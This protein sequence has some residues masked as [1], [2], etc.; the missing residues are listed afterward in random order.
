M[1][2]DKSGI[3][4]RGEKRKEERGSATRSRRVRSAPW[5]AH[6]CRPSGPKPTCSPSTC[7]V[8]VVR[9]VYVSLNHVICLSATLGRW[10]E[11]RIRVISIV[12]QSIGRAGLSFKFL[13]NKG[14]NGSGRLAK[15]RFRIFSLERQRDR[16]L[17][18]RI[19]N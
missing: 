9:S 17:L 2:S 8:V 6:T 7:S 18:V 16:E 10:V 1:R 13:G 11:S 14:K 5:R 12:D 15:S 19:L 3:A 4:G